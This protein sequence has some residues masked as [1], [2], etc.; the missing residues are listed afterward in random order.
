MVRIPKEATQ[1]KKEH[2]N[3]LN[4]DGSVTINGITLA[5]GGEFAFLCVRNGKSSW[6]KMFRNAIIKAIRP[7][8]K[9]IG[10]TEIDISGTSDWEKCE[11]TCIL[12]NIV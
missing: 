9:D 4:E 11:T 8:Y 6:G 5:A 3:I 12:A 10:L 1:Y 2:P 7:N